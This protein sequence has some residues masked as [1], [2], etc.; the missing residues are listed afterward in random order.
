M[1]MMKCSGLRV[2]CYYPADHP[3]T[4]HVAFPTTL[5]G[6]WTYAG[7]LSNNTFHNLQGLGVIRAGEFFSPFPAPYNR[8]VLSAFQNS[9]KALNP[10]HWKYKALR[11]FPGLRCH[12]LLARYS[13]HTRNRLQGGPPSLSFL[14]LFPGAG[15]LVK[16]ALHECSRRSFCFYDLHPTA[17]AGA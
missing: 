9:G 7:R 13:P 12:V 11:V 15:V 8:T 14:A 4:G 17:E 1:R 16:G 6:G 3:Q 2:W 10:N 5:G